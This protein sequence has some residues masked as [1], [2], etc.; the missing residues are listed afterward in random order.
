MKSIIR[1]MKNIPYYEEKKRLLVVILI[2]FC[3]IFL[4]FKLFQ[5]A[6]ASYES[7]AKINANIQK[8]L[9][10]LEEGDLDF[11]IDLEQIIPSD[12]PYVYKFSVSNFNQKTTS[13]IDIEYTLRI[14]TTTNLP[15]I[16]KLYRNENH[17]D[18]TATNLIQNISTKQDVDHA[19]YNVAKVE[20]TYTFLYTE[21][22]TDIYTL[23]INF[24]K[25]Y[26]NNEEYA[27][28]IE[29]IIVELNSKQVIY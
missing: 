4:V 9:Y 16:Y 29:N 22:K 10:I 27:D 1:K 23:V 11:N 2:F 14:R 19:W 3:A 13:D 21:K 15:L 8:A 25:E 12:T 18:S 5:V 24:P 17:D 20:K 7:S 6:Y 26:K 28:T